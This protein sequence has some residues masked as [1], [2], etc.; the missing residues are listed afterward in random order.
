[1]KLWTLSIF[2]LILL[3]SCAMTPVQRYAATRASFNDM[4]ENQYIPF[5][6]SQTSEVQQ[7]LRITIKP[8][9]HELRDALDIYHQSLSLPS[10][11]PEVKLELYLAVKN[12][13]INLLTTYG[14]KL[15][16][17]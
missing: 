4:L 5:F 10:E 14:L 17:D 12:K 1:M 16:E 15:V 6:R 13:L 7:E 3:A 11:N 9:I 8:V 2:A